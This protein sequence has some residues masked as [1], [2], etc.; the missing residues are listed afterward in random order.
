MTVHELIEALAKHPG[1]MPVRLA[2]WNEGYCSPADVTKAFLSRDRDGVAFVR[3]DAWAGD[4]DGK[5]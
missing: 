4:V 3:L 5:E 1:D 2:D